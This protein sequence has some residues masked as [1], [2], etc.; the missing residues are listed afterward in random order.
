M[1]AIRRGAVSVL[2]VIGLVATAALTLPP[3]A[4]APAG[5]QG[6][7][8]LEVYVGEADAADVEKMRKLGLDAE[9][10][11][12]DEGS[13]GRVKVEVAVTEG[14]AAKLRAEGVDLAVKR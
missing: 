9:S 8:D 14:Q 4:G 5:P 13:A 10:F 1:R 11:V 12:V 7:S 2:T 3:A 6:R